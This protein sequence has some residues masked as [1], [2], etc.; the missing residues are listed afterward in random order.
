M[1]SDNTEDERSLD[2]LIRVDPAA[3][4]EETVAA[5]R[6]IGGRIRTQAGDVFSL[7]LPLSRIHALS[8]LDSVLYVEATEPLYPESPPD[9]T[10]E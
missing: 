3:S 6:D 4:A 8:Q 2:L 10:G 5:I 7:S 9:K 1:N